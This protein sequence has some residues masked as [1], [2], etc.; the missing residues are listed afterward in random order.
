MKP[1]ISICMPSYN[2]EDYIKEAIDSVLAQ[3][4]EN[5]ELI[6][7]DDI[8]TD[9]TVEIIKEYNDPRIKFFQNSKN[10]HIYNNVNKAISLASGEL[11]GIIHCDDKYEKTF[12]EK[13]VKSY[14]K[15]PNEKVFVTA[16]CNW[17]S[18]I[19]VL[20]DWH[21]FNSDGVISKAEVLI[22]LCFGNN[23]G[24][25]VN[26]V[27]HRDCFNKV[28]FFTPEYKG[29]GDYDYWMRLAE[30]F[31]FVYI[32]EVL[33][34]YR[35]HDSNLTHSLMQNF[36]MIKEGFDVYY[37]N[38]L[39]SS[40]LNMKVK[41]TISSISKKR[42]IIKAFHTGMKYSSGEVIRKSLEYSKDMYPDLVFNPYWVLFYLYSYF[43]G[44]SLPQ[45]TLKIFDLCGKVLLFPYQKFT[46]R[47]IRKLI[48]HT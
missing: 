41:D 22:R 15:Y 47:D 14:N 25:G 9:N 2:G 31:D 30:K 23:I 40:I 20:F 43:I 48:Q 16:V 11:V 17:H 44:K 42:C 26:V 46:D 35:I 18:N 45:L 34:Y 24:N 27:L 4:Y 6:I 3:T 5:F 10:L 19:N 1:L 32:P 21:P 33:A 36:D 28:G 39:N 12:L 8:S 37:E 38:I 7:T 13:I 29:T